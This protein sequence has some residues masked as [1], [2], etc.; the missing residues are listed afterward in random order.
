EADFFSIGSN[1]LSQY[2]LAMDRG[3]PAV[4]AQLDALHPSV[5]RLIAA[6]VEGGRKR[7]RWTGV[8]GGMAADPLAVPIL[9]GLGV[10]ELSVPPSALAE[11]KERVRRTSRAAARDLAREAMA[12]DGAE[13]VRA[14]ARRFVEEMGA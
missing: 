9:I 7:D 6:T 2:A 10:T 8:C 13:A 14:L 1:D 3:N 12:A 5:L 4:A 11:T